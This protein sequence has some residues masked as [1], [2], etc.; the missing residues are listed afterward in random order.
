MPNCQSDHWTPGR[1][2]SGKESC[3]MV[4]F[5]GKTGRVDLFKTNHFLFLKLWNREKDPGK[6]EEKDF[7]NC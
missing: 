7:A 3:I 1:L 5:K 4:F 6:R 2:T